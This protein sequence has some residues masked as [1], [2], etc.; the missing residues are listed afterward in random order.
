[1]NK[2]KRN[3]TEYELFLSTLLGTGVVTQ[4]EFKMARNRVRVWIPCCPHAPP[5]I[6]YA[7]L[8]SRFQRSCLPPERLQRP[9]S[10]VA[11]RGRTARALAA[12][13]PAGCGDRVRARDANARRRRDSAGRVSVRCRIA[14]CG[15]R[16]VPLNWTRGSVPATAQ[17]PRDLSSGRAAS[18]V[19][20]AQQFSPPITEYIIL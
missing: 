17:P 13:R 15:C 19:H 16:Y 4:S 14:A 6:L 20:G 7:S 8:P 18:E 3:D 2:V 11:S 1:M 10:S 12:G 9:R 5:R